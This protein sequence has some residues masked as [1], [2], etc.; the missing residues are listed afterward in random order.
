L[1]DAPIVLLDEP[2]TGLDA[3]TEQ[4]FWQA[5]ETVL[6]GKTVLWITHNIEDLSRMDRVVELKQ[7]QLTR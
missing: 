4:A 2:T 1:H 6:Q 5:M 3:S 7:G